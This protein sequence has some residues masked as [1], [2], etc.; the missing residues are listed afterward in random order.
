MLQSTICVISLIVLI[1][2]ASSDDKSRGASPAKKEALKNE[3]LPP[4]KLC[5]VLVD[6]FKKGM[7]K[8]ASSNFQGGDTAWEEEKLGNYASSEVRFI[9]IQEKLCND[10]ERGNSQ[11][12]TLAEEV[13]NRLEEWWFK[14]RQT[15]PD[16][17]KWLCVEILKHCCPADHFGPL[18]LPCPGSPSN[19]CSGNGKCR[20]AGTRKGNGTCDCDEG[21]FGSHCD[22]CAPSYYE[23]YRD[24]SKLLCSKCHVACQ[25]GCT[26]AGPRGCLA[27]NIGW[28]HDTERGC[29]D[30]NE[31]VSHT[32]PCA[33]NQFCVN[34]EG[35]YT[36]LSCDK[37]C[38]GCQGDGPDMCDKCA[39][40]FTLIDGLCIGESPEWA[41]GNEMRRYLTYIGLCIATC[42]IFQKN[43]IVASLVGLSVAIYVT[44]SEYMLGAG[45]P[46]DMP[47]L[48]F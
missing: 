36:C 4:C 24:E 14:Q 30:I 26:R 13:E 45:F 40:G 17:F 38:S 42:I 5:K 11:C 48:K 47:V 10:V 33:K 22:F 2:F 20:G 41:R 18:C 28:F 8:T 39:D 37:A 1:S 46:Q 32:N 44:L 15:E 7:D 9:E 21:Y 16:L 3:A 27:C 35:S 19:I 12:H 29:V 6:S 23:S 34:N 31:C 43:P 25:E